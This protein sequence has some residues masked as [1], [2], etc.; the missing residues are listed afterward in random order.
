MYVIH[1][2]EDAIN[3][4]N[5]GDLTANDGGPHA[6]DETWAFY[7]GSLEGTDGSGDGVMPYALADKRCQNFAVCDGDDDGDSLTGTSTV[8]ANALDLFQEG[9]GYLLTGDCVSVI[10]SKNE[11]VK[12]MTIP[13][14]QG[15]LRYFYQ[16]DP[17]GFGGED[18]D[19]AWGE[20]WAFAASVLPQI[21]VCDSAVAATIYANAN[22]NS[23]SAPMSDG[24]VALKE[25]LESVYECLDV[26][27]ADIGGLVTP[28]TLTY[29]SGFEPCSDS[30]TRSSKDEFPDWGI[31]L[32]CILAVAT[33]AGGL[34]VWRYRRRNK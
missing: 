25:Q 26:T 29:Y 22:I 4:C 19:K 17:N 33:V 13:L 1:E 24:Y 20:L 12:Q 11:I 5:N 27:C 10:K 18:L 23:N 6:W 16:A 15:L 9:L 21:A 31:A 14:L 28:G 34:C 32:I 8:N 3:D 7:A 30:S 2:M